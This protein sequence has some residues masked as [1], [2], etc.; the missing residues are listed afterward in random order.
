VGTQIKGQMDKWKEGLLDRLT[1][2]R[3][4]I[5]TDGQCNREGERHVKI[6]RGIK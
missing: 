1:V 6:I 3:R 4:D 5:L 2:R